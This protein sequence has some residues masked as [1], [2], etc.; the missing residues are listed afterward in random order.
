MLAI[1]EHVRML[2]SNNRGLTTFI[3][4]ALALGAL[5]ESAPFVNTVDNNATVNYIDIHDTSNRR[6][7][8]GSS[9]PL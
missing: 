3:S 9:P 6:P 2:N 1:A 4:N 7:N 5:G 8:L